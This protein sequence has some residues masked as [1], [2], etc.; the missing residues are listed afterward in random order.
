MSDTF[1]VEIDPNLPEEARAYAESMQ[2]ADIFKTVEI[3]ASFINYIQSEIMSVRDSSERSEYEASISKWRRQRIARPEK[4]TKNTPFEGAANVCPPVTAEKVNTIFAKLLGN[5]SIKKPFWGVESEDATL[6]EAAQALEHLMNAYTKSPFHLD[7]RNVNRGLFYDLVSLGTEFYEIGWIFKEQM[8]AVKSEGGKGPVS[9]FRTVKNGPVL[10]PVAI[11]DFFTR[12]YWSDL[13]RA[14]WVAVRSTMT[15]AEIRNA[16]FTGEYIKDAS[17]LVQAGAKDKLRQ[18]EQ[19][20]L[21]SL[22]IQTDIQ[23]TYPET[24]MYELYSFYAFWDIAGDGKLVD[25]HGIIEINSGT[26]LR[27]DTN[28]IGWRLIGRIPYFEIPNQLYAIGVAHMCEFLQ[29]ET[30]TIHNLRLDSLKWSLLGQYKGRR[31][32]GLKPDE[33]GYPGKLWLTDQMDDL[34]LLPIPDMS[35]STYQA[36]EIARQYADHITGANSPMSGYADPVLK[37]G[38]GAQAQM[39][40]MQQSSAILNAPLDTVDN[41]Y[42]EIGRLIA[43][44]IVAN[45]KFVDLSLVSETD[46]QILQ[47]QIF[48]LKPEDLPLKFKFNI[49]TTDA[50]RTEDARRQ[51]FMSYMQLYT[52]F[53]Q[54]T[55]Q[56]YAMMAQA[57]GFQP[58]QLFAMKMIVGNTTLMQAITEFFDVGNPGDLLPDVTMLRAVITQQEIAMQAQVQGGGNGVGQPV[59]AGTSTSG[60][61]GG[62]VG[63]SA[64]P[65]VSPTVGRYPAGPNG[66]GSQPLG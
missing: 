41:Y 36:E 16:E 44:L 20:Q 52:V 30:E 1:E 33:R 15:L 21:A 3:E 10:R 61:S 49:K 25:I 57:Q 18:D 24:T 48:I 46:K 59:G 7:L 26:L 9:G 29:D 23:N 42:A 35:G 66:Q 19:D 60:A 47:Q 8:V 54:Q 53:G 62:M 31:G 63:S 55:A 50:S 43:I 51:N 14:P 13:Q 17:T 40:L 4:K 12:P 34:E 32:S 45:S 22:G 38:G 56:Y 39:L 2:A 65:G 11:E 6:A 28:E 58:L 64:Q 37:S 5:Y 27:V